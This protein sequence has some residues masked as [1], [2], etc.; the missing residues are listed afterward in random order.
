M[1]KRK[2][3]EETMLRNKDNHYDNEPDH[4]LCLYLEKVSLAGI[5]SFPNSPGPFPPP[6]FHQ[7][8]I[9]RIDK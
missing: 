9:L 4:H 3:R 7:E 1:K 6:Q 2:C 8:N 5:E